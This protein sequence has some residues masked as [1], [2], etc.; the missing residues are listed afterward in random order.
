MFCLTAEKLQC[1]SCYHDPPHRWHYLPD[2]VQ[3]TSGP[4]YERGLYALFLV[5][6]NRS[7]DIRQRIYGIVEGDLPS[8]LTPEEQERLTGAA[9]IVG[10]DAWD[11]PLLRSSLVRSRL[12][13][14]LD[15]PDEIEM[16]LRRELVLVRNYDQHEIDL[17]YAEEYGPE[18]EIEEWFG[19]GA[20]GDAVQLCRVPSDS[21]PSVPMTAEEGGNLARVTGLPAYKVESLPILRSPSVQALL[22]AATARADEITVCEYLDGVM[23]RNRTQNSVHLAYL[24]QQQRRPGLVAEKRV[25][26]NFPSLVV[27]FL[28]LFS[29]V[30]VHCGGLVRG[31]KAALF[32]AP[33]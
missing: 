29:A 7:P 19:D 31:D 17:F 23:I 11:S 3:R 20:F 28:P 14:S 32:L 15:Q 30:M 18:F 2:R 6:E 27:S 16:M 26:N 1:P 22:S 25:V 4:A 33:R 21:L 5:P 13:T 12:H 10:P 8:A 24:D 9:Q